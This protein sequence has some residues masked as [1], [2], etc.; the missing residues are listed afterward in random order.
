MLSATM[1]GLH[2]PLGYILIIVVLINRWKK[3]RYDFIIQATLFA[4][5]Y[6]LF[7]APIDLF[8]PLDKIIFVLCIILMLVYKHTN[9]ER[10]IAYLMFAYAISM[11][12]FCFVSEVSIKHQYT[13]LI[14]W[15]FPLFYIIP[16]LSFEN[17]EFEMKTFLRKVFPYFFI[18]CVYFI[19]DGYIICGHLF[20]PRDL[21]GMYFQNIPT[22]YNLNI[23][24]FSF[25][26]VRI[27]PHAIIIIVIC[28]YG[29]VRYYK[30]SILQIC[31]VFLALM[32]CR[33]FTF[34]AGILFT[35]VFATPDVKNRLKI[36]IIG[37]ISVTFLFFIDTEP[38]LTSY[39]QGYQS[40]F[41]V[42]STIKQFEDL[43]KAEDEEDYSKFASNR[44]FVAIPAITNMYQMNKEWYGV[45]L[46]QGT[47]INKKF[48]IENTVLE[49]TSDHREVAMNDIEI[50]LLRVFISVGILG[51]FIHL[52]F[53]FLIWWTVRKIPDSGL[54]LCTIIGFTVMGFGGYAGL[55]RTGSTLIIALEIAVILL[56]SPRPIKNY[57]NRR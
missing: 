41:R 15:L 44:L 50:E 22:F 10:R 54:L 3:D 52:L 57:L 12:I 32:A 16:Y 35:W 25:S 39:E 53:F 55:A 33:T 34:Y 18:L 6:S 46:I 51:T 49:D 19:L 27:M 45:G 56:N 9:I 11:L 38:E 42:K 29:V 48:V 14:S 30:L 5:G 8:I 20:I 37:V 17:K 13:Y 47:D 7:S 23:H 43:A 2:F 21:T 36:F 40:L 28:I 24:P 26:S 31:I 4:G 1:I